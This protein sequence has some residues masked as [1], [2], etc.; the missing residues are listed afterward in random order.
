LRN[1]SKLSFE[2]KASGVKEGPFEVGFRGSSYS[3]RFSYCVGRSV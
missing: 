3:R 1:K 2:R